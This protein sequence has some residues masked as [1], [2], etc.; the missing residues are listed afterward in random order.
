MPDDRLKALIAR[1]EKLSSMRAPWESHWQE[2][3]D[4]IN[5]DAS[6]F[7]RRSAPG[8]RK[9]DYVLDG[10]APWALEQLASGLHTFLTS[11]TDRWF[12]LC[13]ENYDYSRDYAALQWLEDISDLIYSQYSKSESNSN[14]SLHELY[15]DLG[16]FGT[17]IE[18]Q[19]FDRKSMCITFRPYPLADCRILENAQGMV[20]TIYRDVEMTTRQIRQFFPNL[21][22]DKIEKQ[23]NE[24]KCWIVTHAVFPRTD[25]DSSK[26]TAV[27]KPFAS[28]YFCKE[29][30]GIFGE[31]GYDEFPYCVP[32]WTKRAGEV[33]G[34]SPGMTCLPDI[35]MVNAMER[36]QL[37]AVQKIVDPPLLTPSDGFMFP[38]E[39]KPSSLIYYEDNGTAPNQR[40]MPLETHGRVEVGEDKMQQKRDFIMRCFYADWIT[41]MHKKERQ[42]ATEIMDDRNEM[43]QMMSPILGRLQT[44]LLGRRLRRTYN[45]LSAAGLIPPAPSSIGDKR[46]SIEYISPAAKAQMAVKGMKILSFTQEITP[47]A[48]V[49]PEILDILNPDQMAQE[50]AIYADVSRRVLRSPEEVA[51][52]RATRQQSQAVATM[53]QTAQP[54][55]A[56]MK[57]IATAKEKGLDISQFV[58]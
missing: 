10:T 38:I 20:D 50:L 48:Q 14:N 29:A 15:Q 36:V 35:K 11:P 21:N 12:N 3:R 42:T 56:A 40:L 24:D 18:Y 54:M 41:R 53:A 27:N 57:D 49:M 51:Q 9:T 22:N 16:S 58:Q 33:Y 39:T 25:R 5:T 1:S 31:S 44:E 34:R 55:G 52:I 28:I 17:A 13:I 7:N 30:D 19:E 2:L 8:A 4:L 32:R 45:L 47:L 23:K 37:R 26:L 43:L 46:L 6:D